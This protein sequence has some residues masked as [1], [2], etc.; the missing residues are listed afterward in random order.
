M[1][2]IS[3]DNQLIFKLV[4][5]NYRIISAAT[6]MKTYL[7]LLLML[8]LGTALH[9]QP[10]VG[11][12]NYEQGQQNGYV[13][14]APMAS[15][16]T[17]L[18]DKEGRKVRSWQSAY[19]P[20]KAAYLLP[21]GS[22][23]RSG[24][25]GNTFFRTPGNGGIIEKFDWDGKLVWSYQISDAKQSQH[26]DIRPL[27]NGNFLAVVCEYIPREEAIQAGRLPER[28]DHHVISEKIVEIKPEGKSAKIVWEWRVWD[29]LV[30]EADR[31]KPH[32]AAVAD[33]PE[34]IHVNFINPASGD[35]IDWLHVNSVA[36]NPELDQII[37]SS[38]NFNEIWVIDHSTTTKEAAS[39]SGGTY[40]KGGDILYRWGNPMTYNRGGYD[41]QK[42]FGQHS[43]K[44]IEKGKP[45]AGKILIFN[46]G[47]GRM[48]GNYSSVDIITPPMDAKGRYILNSGKPFAPSAPEWSYTDS[49]LT[50]FYSSTISG[51]ERLPN[52]NTLVCEGTTGV[53]FEVTP[54]KRIVWKYKNPVWEAGTATQG[55]TING[56]LV[57]R[58]EFYTPSYPAFAKRKIKPE[59]PIELNTEYI[60]P[61]S[62]PSRYPTVSRG[63][64]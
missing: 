4:F 24:N 25:F 42:L 15:T 48:D 36:Y 33:H 35:E 52:G 49:L 44:W 53:F 41:D 27:P 12:L 37:V 30:Q 62:I 61:S 32:F 16:S 60:P 13:L 26:H 28:T 55:T 50:T 39:H 18:I 46:N 10:T 56:N 29:H 7:L 59:E 23:L 58:C 22:L 40:G 47:F 1:R 11:L 9:A 63:M 2:S 17:Y 43:V 31:T 51:A 8:G 6:F 14:F 20:G 5:A 19:K 34:L 3:L 54:D 21:D 38:Y 64:H 45:D 57:F